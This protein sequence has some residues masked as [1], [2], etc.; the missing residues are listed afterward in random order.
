MKG[1]GHRCRKLRTADTAMTTLIFATT[2]S[3]VSILRLL[4]I[5]VRPGNRKQEGTLL[6]R[7]DIMR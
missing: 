7:A 6:D 1:A 2:A 3:F 5:T 4:L